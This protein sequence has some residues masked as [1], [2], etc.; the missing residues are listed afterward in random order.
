VNNYS[1]TAA[2]WLS[3]IDLDFG[4]G[5][6]LASLTPTTIPTSCATTAGA[7]WGFYNSVTG[8]NSGATY[9]PGF[10]YET[11]AGGPALDANPGNNYGDADVDSTCQLTFCWQI[12]TVAQAACVDGISSAVAVNTL[13]DYEV[14]SWTSAGCLNDPITSSPSILS[15]CPAPTMSHPQ[16]L[17]AD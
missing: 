2:N 12:T 11:S 14:G 3:G 16:A 17:P 6:N 8:T 4:P 1:T 15:C 7:A 10:F 9:G 5:W 13:S